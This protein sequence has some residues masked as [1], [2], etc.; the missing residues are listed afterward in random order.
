MA[1]TYG[2]PALA[3]G[4]TGVAGLAGLVAA[5]CDPRSRDLLELDETSRVLV[6]NSEGPVRRGR[7]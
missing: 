3:T 5:A 7:L 4:D 2:D 1:G 6:V